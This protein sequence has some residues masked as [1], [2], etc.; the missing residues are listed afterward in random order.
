MSLA[1]IIYCTVFALAYAWALVWIL[2]RKEKRYGQ[3]SISFTDAFVVG[4]F[5]IILVYL[6]NIVV[7]IAWTRYA[8]LYDLGLITC[9]AAFIAYRET[10]YKARAARKKR[11]LR[12]EARLLE[13]YIKKD[14]SNT[15]YLE[16]LSEV[17]E[18]TGEFK[19]ALAAARLAAKLDPAV[20][21]TWR[22][23]QLEE[24]TSGNA[25]E[26]GEGGKIA[27]D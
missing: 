7:L 2:E 1:I 27:G 11:R 12:A 24:E 9:L 3:G 17:Y 25:P 21:N 23:K 8:F 13:R 14:P 6:S 4:S 15:A 22:V 19:K 10:A 16:R 26:R 5:V 18:K 20:K